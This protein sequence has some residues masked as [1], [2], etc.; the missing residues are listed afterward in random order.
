MVSQSILRRN[1]LRTVLLFSLLL[2]GQL[3]ARK[4]YEDDPL[5][6]IPP[7]RNV[8]R[9]NGRELS[10]YVDFFQHTFSKPGE[11]HPKNKPIAARE[12]NTLGEV[13]DSSWYTNRHYQSPMAIEGL[14]RVPG[15][16]NPPS[17]ERPWKVVAAKTEGVTPGFTV[18]DARGRT[19]VVKFDPLSNP[20]MA[21][22]ADVISS[23]FFYALGYNVPENYIAY[24]RRE[25]LVVAPDAT[26]TDANGK[27]RKMTNR[28]I[29]DLLLHVPRDPQK[30]YRA[31][32]SLYLSG[33]MLGPFRYYGT[34]KDDPND[35]VPH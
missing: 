28:D 6:K 26:I 31:L 34:R 13:P 4:F 2:P 3:S 7:P 32:A 22:A 11:T 15:N 30:G 25:Q 29:K 27:H 10:E 24:F 17:L 1:I 16:E 5:S 20:E 12:V 33:K 35:V 8:D 23:K 9:V 21:S 14:V 19:Y 18:K